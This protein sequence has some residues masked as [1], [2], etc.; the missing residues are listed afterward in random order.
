MAIVSGMGCKSGRVTADIQL[1]EI[2]E[3]AAAIAARGST[4]RG[5]LRIRAPLLF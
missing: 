4:P 1:T 5:K 2:D 3:A